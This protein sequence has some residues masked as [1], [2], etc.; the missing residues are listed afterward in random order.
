MKQRIFLLIAAVAVVAVVAA[1]IYSFTRTSRDHAA[2]AANEQTVSSKSNTVAGAHGE[3]LVKLDLDTQKLI[4]LE[5]APAAAA[6]EDPEVKAY[7]SVLDPTPLV[8][9]VSDTALTRATLDASHKE[10]QRVKALFDRDQNASAKALETAEAAMKR[11]QIAVHT[12]EARL[13]AAWGTAVASQPDLPAFVQSLVKLETV[14]V[15]LDLPAGE[16]LSATPTRARIVR[17]DL[18]GFVAGRFLDR[19]VTTDPQVQGEGFLFV[20]KNNPARLTPGLAVTGLLSLPGQPLRGVIVPDTGV[21]RSAEQAWVYAQTGETT[22]TRRAIALDHPV[23][24]GWFVTNGV[25]AGARLVVSG[26]QLLLSEERKGQIRLA[27]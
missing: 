25:A 22:F 17:A 4:G 15:R 19:A 9:R 12:A 26:A 3:T 7:G 13:V 14:L 23:A 11:D 24:R 8:E 1:L 27:D 5:T 21:V 18:A 16:S 6:T 2:E 20:A 10:Y